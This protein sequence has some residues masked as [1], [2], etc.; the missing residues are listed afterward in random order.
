MLTTQTG[1][2][3]REP[4]FHEEG[5]GWARS[6]TEGA[7]GGGTS[8]CVQGRERRGAGLEAGSTGWQTENG[9]LQGQRSDL[10]EAKVQRD[11]EDMVA[12]PATWLLLQLQPKVVPPAVTDSHLV[13]EEVGSTARAPGHR[14][15]QQP[16]IQ[17]WG[18][19]HTPG[20]GAPFGLGWECREVS[21][22][23]SEVENTKG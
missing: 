3:I 16:P 8:D 21:P 12:P 17:L 19:R 5:C 13:Q 23:R 14:H 4:P 6:R 1:P 10:E 18:E 9:R 7:G 15:G 11:H 2:E 22:G 20:L